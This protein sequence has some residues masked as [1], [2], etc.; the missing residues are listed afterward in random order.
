[1]LAEVLVERGVKHFESLMYASTQGFYMFN[2]NIFGLNMVK[3]FVGMSYRLILGVC[4]G[5]LYGN[6]YLEKFS[7]HSLGFEYRYS[8]YVIVGAY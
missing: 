4:G 7:P 8:I 2:G 1:M 3:D 5:I 6:I